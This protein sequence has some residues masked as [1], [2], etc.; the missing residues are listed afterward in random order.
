MSAS[1]FTYYYYKNNSINDIYKLCQI[2]AS[3][4]MLINKG[5]NSKKK[6]LVN[7]FLE[8]LSLY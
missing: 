3:D 8:N 1:N 4:L 6:I 2:T 7:Q 5:L